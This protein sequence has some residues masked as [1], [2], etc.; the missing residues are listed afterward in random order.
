MKSITSVVAFVAVA[1][2]AV[3][4]AGETHEPPAICET[5]VCEEPGAGTT[6][7]TAL[8]CWCDNP[9]PGC[10][11]E[12]GDGGPLP[13]ATRKLSLELWD[14]SPYARICQFSYAYTAYDGSTVSA[15]V[16]A[17]EYVDADGWRYGA[18]NVPYGHTVTLNASCW[19]PEWPEVQVRAAIQLDTLP[20]DRN[21]TC[22]ANYD[23]LY[24]PAMTLPCWET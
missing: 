24:G 12:P 19:H 22:R 8:C 3:G 23:E 15:S 11:E 7:D 18:V 4:C 14:A 5:G 1:V 13:G 6:E 16:V 21:R 9:P 2:L 20:M 17:G 10:E